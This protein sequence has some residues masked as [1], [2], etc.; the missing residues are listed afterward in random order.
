MEALPS[1]PIQDDSPHQGRAVEDT[2]RTAADDTVA[3][4]RAALAAVDEATLD[5]AEAAASRYGASTARARVYRAPRP[6]GREPGK[7]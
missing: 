7:G 4:V 1:K 6:G 2:P 3:Q 5:A